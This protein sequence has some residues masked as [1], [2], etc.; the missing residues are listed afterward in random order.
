MSE[1]SLPHQSDKKV[2]A[3]K[4]TLDPLTWSLIISSGSCLALAICCVSI[5]VISGA[6]PQGGPESILLTALGA[7]WL[8][9]VSMLLAGIWFLRWFKQLEVE[10]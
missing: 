5:I 7:A 1:P 8:F 6:T 9:V 4:T 2:D 3:T 10:I